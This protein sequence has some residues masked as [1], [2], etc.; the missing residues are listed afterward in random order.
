MR[1][2]YAFTPFGLRADVHDGGRLAKEITSGGTAGRVVSVASYCDTSHQGDRLAIRRRHRDD[3][4]VL[5][6][7]RVDAVSRIELTAD[8]SVAAD[9]WLVALGVWLSLRGPAPAWSPGQPGAMDDQWR[10]LQSIDWNT[11]P[12]GRAAA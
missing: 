3:G 11:A 7:E 6:V 2:V 4:A 12:C 1:I 8:P 5:T 9:A 10:A